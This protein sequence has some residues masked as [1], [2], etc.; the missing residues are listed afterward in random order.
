MILLYLNAWWVLK[1]GRAGKWANH[2]SFYTDPPA[3]DGWFNRGG[4]DP[5]FRLREAAGWALP[6][7]FRRWCCIQGNITFINFKSWT[8]W[9]GDLTKNFV[10]AELPIHEMIESEGFGEWS[11]AGE[12]ARRQGMGTESWVCEGHWWHCGEDGKPCPST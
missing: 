9:W 10:G 3:G 12:C 11:N 8:C 5:R 7:L 4:Q 2:D 1:M 6:W